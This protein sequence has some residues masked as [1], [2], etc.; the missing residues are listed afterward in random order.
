[1]VKKILQKNPKHSHIFSKHLNF[2]K[3]YLKIFNSIKRIII[4]LN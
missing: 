1:M 4:N 2:T 3:K